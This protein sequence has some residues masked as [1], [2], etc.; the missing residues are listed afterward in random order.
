M[1][2]WFYDSMYVCLSLFTDMHIYTYISLQLM[3]P[4]QPVFTYHFKVTSDVNIDVHPCFKSYCLSGSWCYFI[5]KSN[6]WY[7]SKM[8]KRCCK[9]CWMYSSVQSVYITLRLSSGMSSVK[10]LAR[11]V[12]S[13]KWYFLQGCGYFRLRIAFSTP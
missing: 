7:L 6:Q 13:R 8:W 4:L 12:M 9:R 3:A 10:Q 5:S 2:P 1:I 11:R